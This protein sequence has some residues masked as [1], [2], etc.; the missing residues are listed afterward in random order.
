MPAD[1]L[2]R[3]EVIAGAIGAGFALAVQPVAATTVTTSAE[4]LDAGDVEIPTGAGKIRGYRAVASKRKGKGKAPVVLVVHEIFGVHEHI[5]DVCRRLA[6]QGLFAVAPDLFG[7]QG[8]A[9]SIA[10]MKEL[11]EKIVSK[12][13]DAQV[14]SDLDAAVAWAK[15]SGM[16]DTARLGITGFCWGGR[17][18][19]LYAAHNPALKAGV[20]WYGRLVGD[21]DALRPR[22]PIDVAGALVAPVLGLYGGQDKGIPVATVEQMR[23]ALAAGSAAAKRSE[24]K[25]Y[26]EAGHAFNADYRPSYRAEAAADGWTRLLAWFKANGVG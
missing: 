3:R 25:V 7:R 23:A 12:V 21:K 11:Q 14:M 9:S 2:S 4:G 19:W 17:V 8:D 15:T 16:A 20:A 22:H 26:P 1:E 6:R 5:K 24:I 10:D 18:T 13:A